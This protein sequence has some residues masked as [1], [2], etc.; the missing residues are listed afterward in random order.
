MLDKFCAEVF[1]TEEEESRGRLRFEFSAQPSPWAFVSAQ[2]DAKSGKP[3]FNF[4]RG[5]TTLAFC[6]RDGIIV[7]VDSRAS[8]GSFVSSETVRKIIDI[9]DRFLG[10]MAGGAADCQYWQ[11]AL[12]YQIALYE[13]NNQEKISVAGA[14]KMFADML[15]EYRGYGLSLGSMIVGSDDTGVHLYYCDDEGK[16]V[17]GDRF[18]VGSGGTYAYGVL[19]THYDFNLGL[20]EAV[21][22][23]RRA[24]SEATFMDSGS[25]GVVRVCHVFPGGWRCVVDAEDNSE[26]IWSHRR[27]HNAL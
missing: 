12:R 21:T 23:A 27:A 18:A 25:G 24:I 22:L 2:H 1:G 7:A 16:R 8:M 11:E 6:F 10:T 20:E 4:R 19:D 17:K 3:L 5:T 9:N 14:S 15:Y 26:L 13:L